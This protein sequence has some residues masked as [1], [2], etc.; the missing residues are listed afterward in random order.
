MRR[1]PQ[2]WRLPAIVG[3]A[4]FLA[5]CAALDRSDDDAGAISPPS[6]GS[7]GSAA[8]PEMSRRALMD[9]L[10]QTVREL[11]GARTRLRVVLRY[12]LGTQGTTGF[13]AITVPP[14][15]A[16]I[17][18]RG[19]SPETAVLTVGAEHGVTHDS[20]FLITR[21]DLLIAYANVEELRLRE[22]VVRATWL[23]PEHGLQVGDSAVTP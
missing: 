4:V 5:S 12:F 13:G 20:R 19:V 9:K 1:T 8:E 17:S 2:A 21:N 23:Q 14:I 18:S 3:T 15:H 22:C 7:T 10:G 16:T 6:R 11:H